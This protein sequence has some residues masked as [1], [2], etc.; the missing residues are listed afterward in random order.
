MFF[1]ISL[2]NHH[3]FH[4]FIRNP[5][6]YVAITMFVAVGPLSFVDRRSEPPSPQG[7]RRV[8]AEDSSMGSAKQ[9]RSGGDE[10]CTRS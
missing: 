3:V 4:D 10:E 2:A 8:D 9:L 5:I 7:C 1:M 6:F